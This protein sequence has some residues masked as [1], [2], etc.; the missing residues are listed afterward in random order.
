MHREH[1][2]SA[3]RETTK[4]ELR[5]IKLKEIQQECNL[6]SR[7]SY[8]NAADNSIRKHNLLTHLTVELLN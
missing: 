8:L 1:F 2:L 5:N 6:N 3:M 4:N 7:L